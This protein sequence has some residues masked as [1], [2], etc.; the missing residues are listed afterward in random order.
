[1]DSSLFCFVENKMCANW[2]LE[3]IWAIN[4]FDPCFLCIEEAKNRQ[5]PQ[6]LN[7]AFHRT[8]TALVKGEESLAYRLPAPCKAY[9]WLYV[10]CPA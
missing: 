1:M 7:S 8:I 5:L 6:R 2:K 9:F 3:L 10:T 4:N